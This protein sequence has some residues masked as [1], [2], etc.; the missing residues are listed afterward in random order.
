MIT[1][2]DRTPIIMGIIANNGNSGTVGV[3]LGVDVG[4][5]A[6]KGAFAG[7]SIVEWIEFKGTA[8]S[9]VTFW[10]SGELS[11]FLASIV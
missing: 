6:V 11:T 2:K 9:K 7:I 5:F 10:V 3:G 4:E 8:C 1:A